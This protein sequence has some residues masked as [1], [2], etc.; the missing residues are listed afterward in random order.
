MSETII[1]TAEEGIKHLDAHAPLE[2]GFQ[3]AISDSFTF[4]GKPDKIGAG[5]AVLL[6]KILGL[7]YMPDG[8][9]QKSGFRLYA[10]KKMQ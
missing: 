5:M 8:F 7:G 4:A 3:L 2:D 9:E 10:Y 6:D 1:K